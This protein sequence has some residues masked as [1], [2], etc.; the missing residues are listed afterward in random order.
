M[1]PL[2]IYGSSRN[3]GD[4]WDAIQLV[5][6]DHDDIPIVNLGDLDISEYDYENKNKDDDFLPLAERMLAHDTIVLGTPVY[7]YSMS[8]KMKIFLDRWS[9]ITSIRKDIGKSLPGKRMFVIAPY[10]VHPEGTEGFDI[11]F[12]ETCKYMKMEYGGCYYYYTGNDEERAKANET[13]AEEVSGR[14]F[15]SDSGH[16]LKTEAV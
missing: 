16:L 3:K 9:D 8:A 7:W 15:G 10:A 13:L 14:I 11:A 2:I 12:K 1:T 4:T 6:K 5:C